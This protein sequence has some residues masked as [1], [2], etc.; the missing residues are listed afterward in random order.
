MQICI[1]RMLK[2]SGFF[3]CVRGMHNIHN[4]SS[5]LTVVP[6]SFLAYSPSVSFKGYTRWTPLMDKPTTP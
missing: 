1:A 3:F 6:D 5:E 4:L 2:E